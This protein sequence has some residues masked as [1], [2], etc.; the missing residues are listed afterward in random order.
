[1]STNATLRVAASHAAQNS[2]RSR[3]HVIVFPGRG[4]S[5]ELYRRLG[6][7]VAYDGYTVTVLDLPQVDQLDTEWLD[8]VELWDGAR[9]AG[10][11]TVIGADSGAYLAAAL[12]TRLQADAVVLAGIGGLY[13]ANA[14][15][16]D[17]PLATRSACPVFRGVAT[18]SRADLNAAATQRF[19]RA[20]AARLQ[21]NALEV[22]VLVLHGE[23]DPVTLLSDAL[24]A[25]RAL[26]PYA[27]VVT[28]S[29]ALHDILNETT[30]RST[31]AEIVQFL[32]RRKG[33]VL[34]RLEAATVGGAA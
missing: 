5:E 29:G 28:V 10:P 4:E 20:V 15:S 19:P 30:H 11:I 3:G 13:F 32:E 17:D 14:A 2:A 16:D 9:E 26:A 22:P 7:R 23:D 33:P 24:E 6:A 34:H 1:M 18:A 25:Y 8:G 31:S 27:D 12:A 21:V